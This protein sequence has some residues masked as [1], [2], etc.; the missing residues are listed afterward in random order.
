M[1]HAIRIHS[2]GGPEVLSWD[3]V[4]VGEPGPGVARIRHSAI[5]LN[6]IDI[7]FRTGQYK[8]PTLPAVLGSEGAGVVEEIGPDVTEVAPGDRVVYCMGPPG[9]YAESRLVPANRLIVLPKVIEDE[10]AAATF[11]QG[12]TAQYLLRRTYRVQEGDIILLHAA[13]GGVGLLVSQWAK[14]LG[15]TVIGTVS[16][17]AKAEL[18]LAHGCDHVILYGRDNVAERVREITNGEGVAVAYDSVGRDTFDASLDSLRPLGML[19]LF[20]QASG[21]VPPF[22]LALL[23]AKGSLFITRPSLGHY[24]AK[25]GDLLKM[26]QELFEIIGSGVVS[27]RVNQHYALKDAAEAHRALEAR[28]TTGSTVLVP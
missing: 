13:A 7:Y 27:V 22:D 2:Y 4:P 10:T 28:Q 5:G 21:P 24:S 18:A 20:G 17:E 16:T 15:A 3:E 11:L 1:T 26:S 19:A 14:H 25:R 9:A 8:L 6:Y 23:G 12:L